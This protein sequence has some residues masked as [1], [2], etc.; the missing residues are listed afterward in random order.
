[1]YMPFACTSVAEETNTSL[2]ELVGY[3]IRFDDCC[4]PARTKIKYM[5]DGMLLRK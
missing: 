4:D 2:G 5:T 1:M 3:S